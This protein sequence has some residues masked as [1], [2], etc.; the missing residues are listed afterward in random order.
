MHFYECTHCGD[1]DV[2][3]PSRVDVA[4]PE[5]DEPAW[6]AWLCRR[7]FLRFGGRSVEGNWSANGYTWTSADGRTID[8]RTL[9]TKRFL[10]S[11]DHDKDDA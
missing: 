6:T 11:S 10:G 1:L 4:N 2:E 7:C 9:S 3:K 5:T 8:I